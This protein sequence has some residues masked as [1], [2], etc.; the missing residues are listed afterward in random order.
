M[1]DPKD[2]TILNKL[3]KQNLID[4]EA[5]NQKL[6]EQERISV[7]LIELAQQGGE[8]GKNHLDTTAELIENEKRR[9]ESLDLKKELKQI[10]EE[11]YEKQLQSIEIERQKLVI[12]EKENKQY[13]KRNNLENEFARSTSNSFSNITGIGAQSKSF[14]GSMIKLSGEGGSL[15]EAFYASYTNLKNIVTVGNVL[16][17]VVD[18]I[19]GQTKKLFF[20]MDEAF[21]QFEKTAGG[22]DAFKGRIE[23]L[24]SS[25]VEYAVSI[26]EAGKAYSDLKVGFAGFAGVSAQTQDQL[27]QTTV[28][29]EKLGVSSSETIKIQNMLV[30]GFQMTGEQA[31][32]MQKQLMATAKAMGLPMQQVVKD[33][34]NAS[35]NMKAH[36]SNMQKVF[37]DLQNQSKNLGIEFTKLQQITGKFDTFEGAADS[38]GKLNAILGGDYLNSLDL[39][40]ADEAERVRLMQEALKASGKTYEEMSKQERMAAAEALGIQDVTELQQLMNNEVQQGTVE[41]LNKAEAEKELAKSVQDVTTMQEKLT[42][43]MAQFA[44]VLTPILDLIKSVLTKIGEWMSKSDALKYTIIGL[45]GAFILLFGIIKGASLIGS[46]VSGFANFKNVITGT[47]KPVEDAGKGMGGA[48]KGIA[49]G[50]SSLGRAASK[51]AGGL[52]AFGLAI[53]LI[54]AGIAVASLGLAQLVKAFQGLSGKQII[55]ALLGL[56][57]VL[58]AMIAIITVL[59]VLMLLGIGAAAVGGILALGLAFLMMGAAVAVAAVGISQ[60]VQAMVPLGE[61]LVGGLVKALEIV[62]NMFVKFGE[63]IGGVLV[64]GIKGA[65]EIFRTLASM[66]V[67]QLLVLGPALM[68]IAAG[69]AA[70]AAAGAGAAVMGAVSGVVGGVASFLTGGESAKRDPL[71]ML[72]SLADTI[73]NFPVSK[74]TSITQSIKELMETLTKSMNSNL[75]NVLNNV[76]DLVDKINEVNV[77]KAAAVAAI[78]GINAVTQQVSPTTAAVAAS[79]NTAPAAATGTGTSATNLVPVAIYIDSKKVGEILDPKIKQTIQDSLKNINGR[80]VPI[81]G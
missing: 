45:V 29:M 34:A 47:K 57:V 10:S 58:G 51:G 78:T 74:L 39:V 60:I 62:V 15:S 5:M 13:E 75:E 25:N 4:Q 21:S 50:V 43:I 6:E 3:L 38:A 69:I 68:G 14:L 73:D 23:D 17:A 26:K 42:A 72:S 24:R 59:G 77:V 79:T 22:V 30:K 16:A 65:V 37:L 11:E 19:V 28:Q 53:V 52:L 67:G 55:G 46:L 35:N 54:G 61:I 27:A 44:I 18:G 56:I 8:E 1:A 64:E 81:T 49:S 2:P 9:V 33:F 76:S 20:E 70:I 48:L 31:G 41:A 71:T 12:L 80:I 36:G 40:N 32:N 63:I 66:N 7:K